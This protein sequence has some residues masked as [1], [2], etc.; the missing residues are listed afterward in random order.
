MWQI[1]TAVPARVHLHNLLSSVNN[2]N[3]PVTGTLLIAKTEWR[4]DC[5]LGAGCP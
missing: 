2:M 3:F 4:I 5:L 1:K